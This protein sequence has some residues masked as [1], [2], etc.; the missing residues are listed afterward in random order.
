MPPLLCG[1]GATEERHTVSKTHRVM[2]AVPQFRGAVGDTV[3]LQWIEA[4]AAEA[5]GMSL[6]ATFVPQTPAA[7]HRVRRHAGYY[8]I[9]STTP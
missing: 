2:L 9:G 5:A 8:Q 6:G 3:A 4:R 1:D 7:H